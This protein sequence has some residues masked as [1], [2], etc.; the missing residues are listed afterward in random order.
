M[1]NLPSLCEFGSLKSDAPEKLLVTDKYRDFSIL[2]RG[3]FLTILTSGCAGH[4]FMKEWEWGTARSAPHSDS[5]F[6]EQRKEVNAKIKAI[7]KKYPQWKN[8]AKT[9][10]FKTDLYDANGRYLGSAYSE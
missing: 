1:R 4:P 7:D 8:T 5:Y 10:G 6:E 3:I 2:A 9:K